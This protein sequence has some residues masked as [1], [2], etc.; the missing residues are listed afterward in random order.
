MTISFW[1]SSIFGKY[2]RSPLSPIFLTMEN[3]LTAEL[4]KLCECEPKQVRK[5]VTKWFTAYG[6]KSSEL[7]FEVD[8]DDWELFQQLHSVLEEIEAKPRLVTQSTLAH[9]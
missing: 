4:E 8:Q 3:Q 9:G 2:Y 5:T 6:L 7:G 1:I